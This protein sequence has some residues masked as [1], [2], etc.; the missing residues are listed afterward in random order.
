LGG[1]D[2][3]FADDFQDAPGAPPAERTAPPVARRDAQRDA[4]RQ[5]TREARR[6]A[7]SRDTALRRVF[8]TYV[9]ARAVLGLLLASVPWVVSLPNV[10]SPLPLILLCLGYAAQ[11]VTLWMR[12]RW[13][14]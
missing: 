10:H 8:R 13:H 12:R 3:S 6:V 11:S 1:T 2:T 7:T 5:Q 9:A 14:G 4:Q